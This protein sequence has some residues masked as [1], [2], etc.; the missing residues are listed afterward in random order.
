MI[1]KSLW[2]SKHVSNLGYSHKYTTFHIG[3][4][5]NDGTEKPKKQFY[6]W[7]WLKDSYLKGIFSTHYIKHI[8]INVTFKLWTENYTVKNH[9]TVQLLQTFQVNILILHAIFVKGTSNLGLQ[10]KT[11]TA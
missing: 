9:C 10:N 5:N 3:K 4:Q 2:I 1:F 8:L 7:G 6:T 11:H